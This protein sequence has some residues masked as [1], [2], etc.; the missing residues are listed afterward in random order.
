MSGAQE[1]K[2]SSDGRQA[3][4]SGSIMASLTERGA[5]RALMTQGTDAGFMSPGVVI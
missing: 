2:R 1:F 4:E 3:H 5:T